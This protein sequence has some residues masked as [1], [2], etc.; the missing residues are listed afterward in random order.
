MITV[1]TGARGLLG[2]QL[3]RASAAVGAAVGWS[4]GEHAGYRRVD[5]REPDEVRRALDEDRPDV[6]VNCAANPNVAGCEA[7]PDGARALNALAV[8]TLAG[9]ARARGA[10][11]V[12]ISTDYVFD[13]DRAEG[14]TEADPT[15]PL[16]VYGRT[17]LEGEGY[18]LEGEDGLVVRLPLLF[19]PSPVLP[20]TTFPAQVLAALRAGRELAADAVAIRQPTLTTDVAEIVGQLVAGRAAGIVH[21]AAQQGI[22]KYDW[23]RQ[24]AELAGLDPALVRPLRPAPDRLRPVRSYLLDERLAKLRIA[25]PRPVRDSAPGFLATL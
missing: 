2:N 12:Q 10:V 24:L 13:G 21:V 25:P 9:E 11:L 16:S 22:T 6:I 1:V 14:Y 4:S 15:R 17:K 23:A 3:L 19:G 7:D 5:L 20:R 18:C 8:G